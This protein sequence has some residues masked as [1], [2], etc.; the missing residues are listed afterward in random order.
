MLIKALGRNGITSRKSVPAEHKVPV[1]NLLSRTHEFFRPGHCFRMFGFLTTNRA[2][3]YRG[4]VHVSDLNRVSFHLKIFRPHSAH[5]LKPLPGAL[6]HTPVLRTKTL[7]EKNLLYGGVLFNCLAAV[8]P[9]A[10]PP[11]AKLKLVGN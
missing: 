10:Q 1:Q 11:L 4:Y 2:C 5:S 3:Y 7:F 6:L 8:F 9:V